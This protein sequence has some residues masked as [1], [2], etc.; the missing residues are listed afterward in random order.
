[1]YMI[2]QKSVEN[3]VSFYNH[4]E[5]RSAKPVILPKSFKN[6]SVYNAVVIDLLQIEKLFFPSLN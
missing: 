3:V 5:T 1:M 6:L 2:A 4:S